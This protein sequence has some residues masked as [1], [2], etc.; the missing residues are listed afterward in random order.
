M[1]NVLYIDITV[2]SWWARWRLKSPALRLFTQPFIQAH[3]WNFTAKLSFGL[4]AVIFKANDSHIG[5]WRPQWNNLDIQIAFMS[6]NLSFRCVNISL[7]TWNHLLNHLLPLKPKYYYLID[8][9]GHLRNWR[10]YWN[11]PNTGIVFNMLKHA[12][13]IIRM[14]FFDHLLPF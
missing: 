8:D 14:I 4:P 5:N 2:M 7:I 13:P 1:V 3:T 12:Q 10:P 11:D 6:S 9:G